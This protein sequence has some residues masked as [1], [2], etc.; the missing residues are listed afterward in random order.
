MRK[1]NQDVLKNE[2]LQNKEKSFVIVLF[3]NEFIFISINIGIF[4]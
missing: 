2:E 4:M 1:K 3:E